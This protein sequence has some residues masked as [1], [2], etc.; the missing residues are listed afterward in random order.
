MFRLG[1]SRDLE[2]SPLRSHP[3][4]RNMTGKDF[5]VEWRGEWVKGW[6]DGVDR[7]HLRKLR[8]GDVEP[9]EE[10]DLHGLTR[11]EAE[12]LVASTI[13]EAYREGVRCLSVIHGRGQRSQ[14]GPVLK[15][16]CI[17]WLSRGELSTRVLAFHSAPPERGG[18]GATWVLLRRDRSRQVG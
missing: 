9:A 15:T 2:G 12:Q 18:A 11:A 8:R 14:T 5:H 7:A 13:Q 4:A 16:A 6:A 3:T 17:E 10:L 1:R